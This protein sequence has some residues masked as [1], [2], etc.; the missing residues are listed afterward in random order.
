LRLTLV[1]F[2]VPPHFIS[3][4]LLYLFTMIIN[5]IYRPNS[6]K[7]F[8]KIMALFWFRKCIELGFVFRTFHCISKVLKV[9]VWNW[10]NLLTILTYI[11]KQEYIYLSVFWQNFAPF[12]N[13]G[14]IHVLP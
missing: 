13:M 8:D 2:F 14:K 1:K 11:N 4:V 10:P 5:S 7:V 6:V 3:K 9:W 12:F